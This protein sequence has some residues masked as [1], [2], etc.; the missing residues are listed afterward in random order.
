MQFQTETWNFSKKINVNPIR[1][2]ALM[3]VDNQEDGNDDF[4]VEHNVKENSKNNKKSKAGNAQ[5]KDNGKKRNLSN[6]K[7]QQR[8]A[9]L[10]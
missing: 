4:A 9:K 10:W 7:S 5:R 6:Q 3:L 2:A 1:Y 8:A